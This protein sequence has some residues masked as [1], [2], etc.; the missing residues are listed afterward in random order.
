MEERI[1]P[2]LSLDGISIMHKRWNVA[3]TEKE[4]SSM[5]K[6]NTAELQ[7][8]IVSFN[9]LSGRPS[10][11]GGRKSSAA[12]SSSP[13]AP[14]THVSHTASH[15]TNF[16]T[17]PHSYTSAY[18]PDEPSLH[19]RTVRSLAFILSSL[20]STCFHTLRPPPLYLFSASP[21]FFCSLSK[22]RVCDRTGLGWVFFG[23][24]ISYYTFLLT[25]HGNHFRLAQG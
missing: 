12:F 1:D 25:C 13:S 23:C 11:Q 24:Y 22:P 7:T 20:P 17:H 8:H 6:R 18:R 4:Y 16:L 14:K 9:E 21:H 2:P 3:L 10:P 19:P 5:A 15:L